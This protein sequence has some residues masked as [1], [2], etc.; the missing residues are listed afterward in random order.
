VAAPGHPTYIPVVPG[1]HRGL[2]AQPGAAGWKPGAVFQHQMSL[3]P[4]E[5]CRSVEAIWVL[6]Y[7]KKNVGHLPTKLIEFNPLHSAEFLLLK[8]GKKQKRNYHLFEQMGG[9]STPS[10]NHDE[11]KPVS[12]TSKTH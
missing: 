8:N 5:L 12:K 10:I 6:G 1:F 3:S 9:L 4:Y 7:G 11:L 2:G